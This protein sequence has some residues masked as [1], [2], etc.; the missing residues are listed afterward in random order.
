[1][2]LSA[3]SLCYGAA[4]LIAQ[5][6]MSRPRPRTILGKTR[7]VMSACETA[8]DVWGGAIEKDDLAWMARVGMATENALKGS[9]GSRE[10]DACVLCSAGLGMLDH[11]YQFISDKSRLIAMDKVHDE[12]FRLNVYFD[13]D[14]NRSDK[15]E[16]ASSVVK[17]WLRANER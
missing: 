14:L 8:I 16:Q 12:L 5:E 6:S 3:L 15:Y 13:R 10:T 1:M 11:L 4:E 17:E 9:A 2:A 7:R